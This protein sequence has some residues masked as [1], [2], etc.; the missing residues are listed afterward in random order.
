M[1][2]FEHPSSMFV[3]LCLIFYF[4]GLMVGAPLWLLV[5]RRQLATWPRY[6][7]YGSVVTAPLVVSC[8]WVGFH[9]KL[10]L[11]AIVYDTLLFGVG[12]AVAGATYWLVRRPDQSRGALAR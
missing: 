8:I 3:A 7:F 10:A 1:G 6:A 5:I 9:G 11:F 4:F 2:I 12:G